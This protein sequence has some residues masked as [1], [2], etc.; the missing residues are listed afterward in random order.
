MCI[1]DRYNVEEGFLEVDVPV[2]KNQFVDSLDVSAAGRI[3]SY[4]TSGMVQTWKLGATSQLN[5][6]IKLRAS[7]SNDIRAPGVGELFSVALISTQT[8]VVYP[9]PPGV[10]KSSNLSFGAPG[11]PNLVPEQSYTVSGGVV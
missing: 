7:W 9:P 3:T 5:E 8:N 6:D 2:L 4:S 11:N 10:G 1:R